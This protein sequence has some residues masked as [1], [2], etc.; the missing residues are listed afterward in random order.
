[1]ARQDGVLKHQRGTAATR[2]I[3]G[4]HGGATDIE[5]DGG[6]SDDGG[7]LIH[8]HSHVDDV[9]GVQRVVQHSGR[10]GRN[11]S[12]SHAGHSGQ[13]IGHRDSHSLRH[14]AAQAVKS[15]NGDVVDVVGSNAV[16]V[17]GYLEVGARDEAHYAR[18]GVNGE[19]GPIGTCERV[20]HAR[21]A[22]LVG[23]RN[24]VRNAGAVLCKVCGGCAADDGRVVIGNGLHGHVVAAAVSRS[25]DSCTAVGAKVG[26]GGVAAGG[27]G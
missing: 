18:V 24:G 4:L 19:L 1:M 6:Q 3:D 27:G 22:I 20:S 8:R 5:A 25:V 16:V 26:V 7:R 12:D 11:S 14:R 2:R 17:G 13:H 23:S 15:S 10:S 9:T 21:T